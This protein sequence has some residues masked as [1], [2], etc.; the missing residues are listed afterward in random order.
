[1]WDGGLVGSSRQVK[2][3]SKEACDERDFRNREAEHY[4]TYIPK[5]Q[6]LAEWAMYDLM[7]Q[8]G[9]SRVLDLG[10][11]TGRFA[12]REA[13]RFDALVGIDFALAALLLARKRSPS[14]CQFVVAD[15][16]QL[17]LRPACVDAVFS[18]Q[19]LEHILNIDDARRFFAEI[20]RALRPGGRAVISTYALSLLDRL[21]GR[22]ADLENLPRSVRW[23]RS[24]LRSFCKV[25]G[26]RARC[27]QS[28]AIF[29]RSFTSALRRW[30]APV[31]LAKW[32][33]RLS[34]LPVP[35]AALTVVSADK[36]EAPR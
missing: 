9:G 36:V 14:N 10:V 19:V 28:F 13:T 11:G 8:S 23:S 29:S 34:H 21:L 3:L 16:L 6:H 15:V 31:T 7:L 17:P 12:A 24:E 35:W 18:S 2:S 1:V 25:A 5:Y 4:D 20:G 27:L 30:V 33:R 22:K 26:L 32:D